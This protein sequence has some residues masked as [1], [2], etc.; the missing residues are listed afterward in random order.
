MRSRGR[1]TIRPS[2]ETALVVQGLEC[3]RLLSGI[4]GAH[5]P[6]DW[7]PANHGEFVQVPSH[8]E[9]RQESGPLLKTG[10]SRAPSLESNNG[11]VTLR[12]SPSDRPSPGGPARNA[13]I[14]ASDL[15]E[16]RDRTTPTDLGKPAVIPSELLAVLRIEPRPSDAPAQRLATVLG[17]GEHWGDVPSGALDHTAGPGELVAVRSQQRASEGSQGAADL[18]PAG[19]AAGRIRAAGIRRAGRVEAASGPEE[20]VLESGPGQ[21]PRLSPRNSEL[22]TDFLPFDR[23]C[24]A[25][26]IDRFLAEFEGLGA[27]LADWQS[28]TGMLPVLA[29]VTLTAVA[30][31]VARRRSRAGA[32][33]A[34]TEDEDEGW[35]RLPGFPGAWSFAES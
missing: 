32:P 23:S 22:L 7:L 14:G 3:R 24:L 25:E 19:A 16:S 31:E 27:D 34:T 35:A 2:L 10:D 4:E 6:R 28:S 17:S 15:G 26:A 18:G 13:D 30:S 11:G 5:D 21:E 29:A 12:P 9:L 8:D 33:A 1:R 20:L